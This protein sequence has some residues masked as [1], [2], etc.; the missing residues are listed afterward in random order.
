MRYWK[1]VDLGDF[2]TYRHDM[3]KYFASHPTHFWRPSVKT[4]QAPPREAFFNGLHPQHL[5]HFLDHVPTFTSACERFGP[6]KKVIFVTVYAD[7]VSLHIDHTTQSNEGVKARINIP[8]LNCEGSLTAFYEFNEEDFKQ[9]STNLAGVKVWPW[10]WRRTHTPV[11]SVELTEP[12]ILR[13]SAPHT[14]F[15]DNCQYPR[16]ALSVAFDDDVV[17]Y[18]D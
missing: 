2:T 12:T 18:L 11:T 7:T 5:N 8:L 3:L 4:G 16:I 17:R 15:T 14:V 10:E 9:H 1:R 6:I 13:T